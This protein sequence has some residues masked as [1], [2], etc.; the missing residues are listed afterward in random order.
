MDEEWE[1]GGSETAGM[2]PIHEQKDTG[3][4]HG[5][6]NHRRTDRGIPTGELPVEE[7]PELK[8]DKWV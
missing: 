1:K 6:L 5:S 4:H 7:L 3:L 2:R 8:S